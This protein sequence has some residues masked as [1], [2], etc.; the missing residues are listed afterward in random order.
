MKFTIRS[1]L[2]ALF[3]S[4]LESA[5]AVRGGAARLS[6]GGGPTGV[7]AHHCDAAVA[8]VVHDAVGGGVDAARGGETVLAATR[9][10]PRRAPIFG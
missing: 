7:D 9:L 10:G 5:K 2:M 6:A 3:Y 8:G 1:L 4:L